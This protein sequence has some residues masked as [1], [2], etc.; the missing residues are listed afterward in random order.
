MSMENLNFPT[1]AGVRGSVVFGPRGGRYVELAYTGVFDQEAR[2]AVEID[3]VTTGVTSTTQMFFG[4]AITTPTNF[5]Y[6]AAYESDFH[7]PELNVWFSDE[8]WRFRPFLGARWIA[9]SEDFRIFENADPGTGG[10]ASVSNDLLGGQV[11]FQTLL[12]QRAAWFRVQAVFKA[13]LYHNQIG[14]GAN[15]QTGGATAATLSRQIDATSFSGEMNVSAIWQLTPHLNFHAGYTG[16]WLSDVAL[17]GDQYD[18]LDV[19]AGTG[20]LDL[21]NISYQGGHLGVTLNW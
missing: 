3:A 20:A 12:W 17:I 1:E 4:A 6:T 21:G 5:G 19:L 13:G 11:G 10:V 9:Q 14:F 15:L 16:L 18:H 7:S 2:A 8:E